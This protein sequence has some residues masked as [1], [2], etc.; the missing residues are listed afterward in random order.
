MSRPGAAL[1]GGVALVAILVYAGYVAGHDPTAGPNTSTAPGHRPSVQTTP[2]DY[3]CR[4]F[5]MALESSNPGAKVTITHTSNLGVCTR[6]PHFIGSKRSGGGFI[7]NDTGYYDPRFKGSFRVQVRAL[8]LPDI[9][10]WHS[11]FTSCK[12]TDVTTGETLAHDHKETRRGVRRAAT[13]NCV[14]TTPR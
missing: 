3:H 11:D 1:A 6:Y 9:A 14:F 2:T 12:I 7:S 5:E 13:A 10:G 4:P 8:N